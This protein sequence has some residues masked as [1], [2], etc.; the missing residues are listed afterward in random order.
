MKFLLPV[1]AL[2]LTALLILPSHCQEPPA[3]PPA[4]TGQ[5][6]RQKTGPIR[7]NGIA[8]KANGEIITMNEL[9][10]KVA[11][12]QSILMSRFPR[13]GPAYEA[14][15][16]ELRDGIL[17]DLVDRAIIFSEFKDRLQALPDHE[18]ESEVERIIQNVYSG[19]EKLFRDYLKATN[20]T[21]AEFKE[22]QRKEL[23]VQIIRSQH[24]G[25]VPPP[26]EAEL[27]KEYQLW[28]IANR[29]RTKDVATYQRIYLP[30]AEGGGAEAQLKVAE[31]LGEDLKA[32][33]DFAAAAKKYSRDSHAQDGGL[34]EDV[35]RTD[36]NHEFGFILFESEGNG[37][38]GPFE[39]PYG[40]N[41][42]QVVKREFGPSKPFA[43]VRDDMKKRVESEKKKANFEEW[44]KKMRS[45]AI[46]Q[47][48]ID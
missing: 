29:D 36:L 14:Q 1:L 42:I 22:Q 23:L 19:D 37:V 3:E 35:P 32:G 15:L 31:E 25:D 6:I 20:L 2:S 30:K 34:W 12:L 16:K 47:K 41:I 4:Q 45:R 13:R 39:D 21:R 24:F 27:R 44:M 38:I 40:F 10:I 33:G 46:I 17:D 7:V 48:L 5:P 18:V 43:E 28:A 11:P 9:M 8:A 26:K